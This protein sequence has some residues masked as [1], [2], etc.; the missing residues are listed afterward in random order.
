M[1]CVCCRN[2]AD[3]CDTPCPSESNAA[4]YPGLAWAKRTLQRE[5]ISTEPG[6]ESSPGLFSLFSPNVD[7]LTRRGPNQETLPCQPVC[8]PETMPTAPHGACRYA[9]HWQCFSERPAASSPACHARS[10][11]RVI[12]ARPK[13]LLKFWSFMRKPV[14]PK[15]RYTLTENWLAICP[16]SRDCDKA[17]LTSGVV[18]PQPTIVAL[19]PVSARGPLHQESQ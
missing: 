9:M 1:A 3:A 8:T 10:A 11:P 18:G 14:R 6:C 7:L 4:P 17:T 19:R 2:G 12:R 5:A 15:V 13:E 16:V